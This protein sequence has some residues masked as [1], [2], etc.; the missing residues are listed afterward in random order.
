MPIARR[1]LPGLLALLAAPGARAQRL[2]DSATLLMP[3]PDGAPAALWAAR[4]AAGL[5]RGLPHAVALHS[6]A[7]GGPDGVTAANRF[8]TT[9]GAEGRTLLVLPGAAAHARLIGESRAR[10]PVEGWLPLCAAWGGAVLAGRAPLPAAGLGRPIRLALPGPDAPE[11]AALLGLDLAQVPASPVLGLAGPAAE[12]ALARGEVDAI[13]LSG[14]APL[15]QA[16]LLGA[17]P[18]CE[19]DTPSRRDHPELPAL[20]AVATAAPVALGAAQA[21]FA[22]L[23][24]RA[25]VVLP[26][27][28]SADQVAVWRRAA[29]RWQE[30]E[31]RD[32]PETLALVGAE[33]RTAMAALFPP[34]EGVLAYREWLLRRLNWQAA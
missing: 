17:A 25:A 27:L 21:G 2:A 14:A 13:V 19:L 5:T 4:V 6:I 3:G 22:A 20:S 12:Q 16:A 32:M 23:R 15:R 34:P 26:A 28:T 31:A 1:A 30:E 8:A 33:A 9:E 29:L 24:L 7:V 18:W 10:Y 11:A